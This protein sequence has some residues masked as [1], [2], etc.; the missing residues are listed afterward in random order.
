MIAMFLAVPH[1]PKLAAALAARG[2]VAGDEPSVGDGARLGWVAPGNDPDTVLAALG[3]GPPRALLIAGDEHDQIAALDAGA[4][5]V[6]GAEQSDALIAAQLAALVERHRQARQTIGELVIDP[7]ERR[8]WRAGHPIELLP[9]EYRLLTE[10]ARCPGVA[11]S[12]Q[13]LLER[14]CGLTFDP[15]TNVLEVHVSRLRAKLDRGFAV[16]LVR[17]TKGRG[18]SLAAEIEP[19]RASG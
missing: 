2:L 19:V 3:A 8:V 6:F 4:D 17:T 13:Q 16:P 1:R 10:L 9:R 7:V 12:R 5:A 14:V 18:Y 11:V 15:G